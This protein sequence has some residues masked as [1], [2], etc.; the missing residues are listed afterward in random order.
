MM[1]T[2][3]PVSAIARNCL[4]S[5]FRQWGVHATDP[6]VRDHQWNSAL[7]GGSVGLDGGPKALAVD[8]GEVDQYV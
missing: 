1:P 5:R 8:V 2:V 3:P 7:G 6:G 4:S